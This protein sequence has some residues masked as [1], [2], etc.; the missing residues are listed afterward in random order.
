MLKNMKYIALGRSN[1]ENFKH[2]LLTTHWDFFLRFDDSNIAR[3]LFHMQFLALFDYSCP[4]RSK[5]KKNTY[6]YNFPGI[7][8]YWK[9]SHKEH[10]GIYAAWKCSMMTYNINRELLNQYNS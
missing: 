9:I 3:N 4:L 7:L 10:M 2:F 6:N 1:V 5:R 8:H